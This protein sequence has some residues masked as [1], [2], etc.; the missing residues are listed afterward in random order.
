MRSDAVMIGMVLKS[1]PTAIRSVTRDWDADG[2]EQEAVHMQMFCQK[3]PAVL[4]L[5]KFDA[6]L[7]EARARLDLYSRQ[8]LVVHIGTPKTGTTALQSCLGRNSDQLRHASWI[9]PAYSD[10]HGHT[11]QQCIVDD[12]LAGRL[13]TTSELL[14]RAINS[15]IP[16]V[17]LSSE[18]FY[19]NRPRFQIPLQSFLEICAKHFDIEVVC[20]FADPGRFARSLYKQ[21]VTAGPWKH[22]PLSGYAED[23]AHFIEEPLTRYYLDYEEAAREVHAAGAG[24]RALA[25]DTDIIEVFSAAYFGVQLS[26][27]GVSTNKGYP[28]PIYELLRLHN[29]LIFDARRK[30]ALL[31][32][33]QGRGLPESER[34]EVRSFLELVQTHEFELQFVEDRSTFEGFLNAMRRRAELAPQN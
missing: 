11:R 7:A 10:S 13:D 23:F 6:A 30:Q 8:R 14:V 19:M 4:A 2:R 16:N 17:F 22:Y 28:A 34:A 20:V 3:N 27:E 15:G 25:Y 1:E 9:Y 24:F 32:V 21:L 29:I 33:I 18:G 5:A 26:R 31:R 12:L